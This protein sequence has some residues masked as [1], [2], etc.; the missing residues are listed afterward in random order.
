[1]RILIVRHGE[2]GF[3]GTTDAE[4]SLTE[5]GV[6]ASKTVGLFCKKIGISFSTVYCS[7]MVRTQQTASNIMEQYPGT[8]VQTTEHLTPESD[9][10]NIFEE[11][12][13]HTRDTQLLFVTHEPFASICISLLISGNIQS[14][15]VMKNNSLACIEVDGTVGRGTGRLLWLETLENMQHILAEHT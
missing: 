10:K 4:R 2:A 3:D 9:P 12:K 14:K 1:M 6:A 13:H 5:N 15:I 8:P 7:P 11:I